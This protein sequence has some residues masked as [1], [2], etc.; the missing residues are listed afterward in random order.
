MTTSNRFA[1][2]SARALVTATIASSGLLALAVPSFAHAATYAFINQSGYV[3]VVTANDWMTA[4]QNA[5]NIDIHS[6]VF[7]LKNQAD[8]NIVG[9]RF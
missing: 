8:Y 6:G 7:L 3:A 4:I 9:G 2:V 1:S 5:L